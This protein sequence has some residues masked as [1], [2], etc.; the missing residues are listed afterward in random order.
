MFEEAGRDAGVDPSRD[1]LTPAPSSVLLLDFDMRDPIVW[2]HLIDR[3]GALGYLVT[4]RRWY[5]HVTADDVAPVD[6][7]S[8][9]RWIVVAAWL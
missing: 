9:Y 3:M 8:R 5:P 4:Y 7:Q 1:S 2:G 6:G